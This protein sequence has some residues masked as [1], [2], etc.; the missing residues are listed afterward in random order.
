MQGVALPQKEAH[1]HSTAWLWHLLQTQQPVAL[2]FDLLILH[3][4]PT[5]RKMCASLMLSSVLSRQL[6]SLPHVLCFVFAWFSYLWLFLV[7]LPQI[8]TVLN[9]AG[10]Q[11]SLGR[12]LHYRSWTE[13]LTLPCVWSRSCPLMTVHVCFGRCEW[14]GDVAG[15]PLGFVLTWGMLLDLFELPSCCLLE[16]ALQK[17][18]ENSIWNE[19]LGFRFWF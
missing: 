19:T 18:K 4:P 2:Y 15:S 16:A 10:E 11:D 17:D 13:M 6:T 7:R 5:V 9:L 3:M 1:T 14:G 8:P 12:S